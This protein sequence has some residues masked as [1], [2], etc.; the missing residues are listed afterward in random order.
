[1]YLPVPGL[2]PTSSV[3]LGNLCY[4][5]GCNDTWVVEDIAA[6]SCNSILDIYNTS[7]CGSIKC[8]TVTKVFL[9]CSE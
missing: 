3:F 8:N 7:H 6:S 2:K 1:M 9:R 4:S 5:L